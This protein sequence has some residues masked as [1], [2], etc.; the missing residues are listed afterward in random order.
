MALDPEEIKR[1]R[2]LRQQ[3]REKQ[4]KIKRI[5]L[6]L[7]PVLVLLAVGALLFF[8]LRPGSTPPATTP[9]D[10]SGSAALSDPSDPQAEVEDDPNKTV[11][12]LVA[13]GD[14]NVKD[15]V[16]ASGGTTY[17]Y[18]DTFIDVAPILADGDITLLNFEG[19]LC[20]TPY[21]TETASAP[22][23]LMTALSNI[24]VDMIQL[25]NSYSINH[26]ISGLRNTI[27]GV[28]A[29]G[30]EPLGVYADENEY[31]LGKGYTIKEVNGIKIAFIA[32]TKGM[33][34][35]TL[36]P[37]SEH[38]VNVLY[39]DY[40]STY[41]SVNTSA[42]TS[43]LD[44]AASAKPD[45]T[46]V[47]LHWGSE[48]NDNISASQKR[49]L[50]LLKNRGVDCILGTHSHYVQKM[51]FNEEAGTFIAYSLGDFCSDGVRSG[52]EYSV[53]LE[54][55]ITKDLETEETKVTGYNF[56]PIYMV[57]ENNE[58]LRVVQIAP[59]MAAF[60]SAY[61]DPVSQLSY[62]EM[63]YALERIKA[64]IQGS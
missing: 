32:F 16:I 30:M 63:V 3:Q 27:N 48:Y 42:I 26:G 45:F 53:I 62:D 5:L 41:Q 1:K 36:P 56:T 23:E 9:A 57:T 25:A 34:G 59:A 33:D 21:G 61:I 8:L 52:T 51:E 19:N 43:V 20:G 11:V 47:L 28:K 49:I 14:L 31:R 22:Q 2:Q 54:L 60:N 46:V 6:I 58:P 55:E 12:R 15:A 35:M 7:I 44:A 38:C 50:N 37:G 39:S 18:T 17:D 29:A 64:R 24:G 10:P 40:D 13:A 4:K